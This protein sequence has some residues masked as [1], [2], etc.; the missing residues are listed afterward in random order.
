[1]AKIPPKDQILTEDSG[2]VA[3]D[4]D[5]V[6]SIQESG[7]DLGDDELGHGPEMYIVSERAYVVGLGDSWG[8][9]EP[10]IEHSLATK[11]IMNLRLAAR[12]WGPDEPL[13][14]HL[15]SCGGDWDQGMAIHNAIQMYP[16]PVVILNY[17]EA[18]SMSS[19]IYCAGN[20]RLMMPDGKFMFH[21]GYI[22]GEWTGRQFRTEFE[23]W[24]KSMIR[25]K[26]VYIDR[27][28]EKLGWKEKKCDDWLEQKMFEKEDAYL[29]AEE[30]IEMGFTHDIFYGDW[31]AL[32][33]FDE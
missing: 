19:I 4:S 17:A 6:W 27:M 22:A 23:E 30:S 15:K 28:Q 11:V 9:G 13:L 18:R 7:L 32:V 1:M 24:E 5:T 3:Y 8:A 25:M 31:D 10:G 26:M 12:E 33:A 29:D 20:R 16:A 21:T 2:E 14:I